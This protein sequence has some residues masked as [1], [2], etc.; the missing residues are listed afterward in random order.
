MAQ[1]MLG[2]TPQSRLSC[3]RGP[4]MV[5]VHIE[6]IEFTQPKNLGAIHYCLSLP[7][8]AVGCQVCCVCL[9]EFS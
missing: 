8:P 5:G 2:V 7:P 1:D 3:V 6:V 4:H 9:L